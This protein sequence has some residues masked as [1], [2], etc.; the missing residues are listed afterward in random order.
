[1][2][3]NNEPAKFCY[4][5]GEI[6]PVYAPDTSQYIFCAPRPISVPANIAEID[7]KDVNGGQST[8]STPDIPWRSGIISATRS[9]ACSTVLFIFQFPATNGILIMLCFILKCSYAWQL[10]PFQHF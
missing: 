1:M 6:S 5:W 9:L 3:D 8:R 10:Y 2:P 7:N 4:I